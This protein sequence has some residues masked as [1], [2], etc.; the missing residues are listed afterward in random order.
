MEIR[1]LIR[2]ARF[3]GAF[4]VFIQGLVIYFGPL[5]FALFL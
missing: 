3:L 5:A 1:R 2:D 4:D